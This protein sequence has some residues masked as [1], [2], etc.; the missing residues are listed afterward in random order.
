MKRLLLSLMVAATALSAAAQDAVFKK[1][2]DTKGIETVYI[3]K[4]LLS[5]ASG[6]IKL[7]NHSIADIAQK[8]DQ[9]RILN[10]EKPSL[11]R[12]IHKEATAEFSKGKFEEAMR[13]SDGGEKVVVYMRQVGKKNE[14]ALLSM[15]KDELSIINLVGT[16]SLSDIQKISGDQ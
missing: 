7:G 6:S 1:Y 10:C 9:V 4:S 16:L 14:F 13:M 3:S 2:A 15:E 11:V 8:L 5:M 12:T